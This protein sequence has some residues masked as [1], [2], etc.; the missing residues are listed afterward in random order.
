GERH[1]ERHGTSSGA[2]RRGGPVWLYGT[3]AVLAALANPQRKCHRLL[4]TAEAFTAQESRLKDA[5][6]AGERSLSPEK[7]TRDEISAQTGEDAVHQGIALHVAPLPT[8]AIEDV[9]RELDGQATA[10][11]VVLDQPNDP[12][13]IGAVLRSAAAFGAAAVIVPEHGTPEATPVVAKAASG[14]LERVTLIRANNLN[15]AL[16]IL[17]ENGFW[18]AGLDGTA[19]KPLQESEIGGRIALVFGTEGKGLRRL[20]RESCDFLMRIPIEHTMESLN[21]SNAVAV[22]LYETVR[23]RTS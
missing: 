22:T 12:H 1:G 19:D 2:G 5:L 16:G 11:V 6:S 15:R 3:H 21:L 8:K 13:N 14:A 4:I 10:V 17:K 9:M 7:A 20:T 23:R 18:C